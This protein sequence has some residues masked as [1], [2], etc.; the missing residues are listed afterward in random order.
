MNIYGIDFSVNSTAITR[1]SDGSVV[2]FYSFPSVGSKKMEKWQ[3]LKPYSVHMDIN[4]FDYIDVVPY[5]KIEKTSDDYCETEQTKI[6][7]AYNLSNKIIETIKPQPD[8]IF[9][10]EGF[11]FGSKGNSFIDLIAFNS[12][13]RHALVIETSPENIYVISPSDNKKLFSGKGNADKSLM[14]SAFL[15]KEH[16]CEPGLKDYVSKNLST[17]YVEKDNSVKKPIDDI[18][19]SYALVCSYLAKFNK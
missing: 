11:S 19:D 3:I 4:L 8:D 12:M 2:K 1:F 14:L 17:L 5:E 7:N 13:F 9:V 18:I 15:E 6:K 10:F 16:V